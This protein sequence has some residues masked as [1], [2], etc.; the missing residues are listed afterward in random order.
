MRSRSVVPAVAVLVLLLAGCSVEPEPPMPTPSSPRATPSATSA[1]TEEPR[2]LEELADAVESEGLVDTATLSVVSGSPGALQVHLVWDEVP[3][4]D[5]Q[6][7]AYQEVDDRIDEIL[8]DRPETTQIFLGAAP[9]SGRSRGV[10]TSY[11]PGPELLLSLLG[12]TGGSPCSAA[13]LDR[14]DLGDDPSAEVTFD[15]T[16]Q[17]DDLVGL[18]SSYDEITA[19]GV[20]GDDVEVRWEVTVEGWTS[21]DAQL[22]VDAGPVEGRQE[23]LVELATMATEGGA[24][25]VSL[26]DSGDGLSV[27]GYVDA[28]RSPLCEAMLEQITAAGVGDATVGMQ[29]RGAKPDAW[30]CSI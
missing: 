30:S 20:E 10:A 22:R 23:L 7:A 16:V 18:V 28:F 29:L 24:D 14:R 26:V 9:D 13:E 17:A 6:L 1:A 21:T 11:D 5:E 4:P 3:G 25:Q 8:D 2:T 19:I 12:T 27:H 15:C